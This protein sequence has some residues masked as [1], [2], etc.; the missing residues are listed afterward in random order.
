MHSVINFYPSTFRKCLVS[1]S[2]A[3]KCISSSHVGAQWSKS[4]ADPLLVVFLGNTG[5]SK[6]LNFSSIRVKLL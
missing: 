5:E 2:E 4:F 1:S 6:E 3:I